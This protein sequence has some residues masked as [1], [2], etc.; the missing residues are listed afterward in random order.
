MKIYGT[1]IA[2][3]ARLSDQIINSLRKDIETGSASPGSRLPTEKELTQAFNVSRTVIREAIS[4]LH[5]DGLVVVRQGAGIFVADPKEVARSF[6]LGIIDTETLASLRDAY[7][8]RIG[9]ESE[10]AAL[11]AQRHTKSDI[12]RLK[13]ALDRLLAASDNFDFGVKADVAFH[14]LIAQ[15]SKNKAM[16]GF[17][18]F[19][20]SMLVDS[21]KTARSNSARQD[22]LTE[23][24]N[25]EHVMIFTAISDRNADD[26]RRYTRLHL[27][28][29]MNRLQIE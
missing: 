26:A 4:R 17:Q 16:L 6:R 19:L 13:K 15:L 24:V 10:A 20:A 5:S 8:L 29:A 18:E 1:P 21:V 11:A 3:P 7:E 14:H 25:K 28:N 22:G 27:S 9:T 2:R 23:V 12:A